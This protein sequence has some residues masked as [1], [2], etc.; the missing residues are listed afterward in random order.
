MQESIGLAIESKVKRDNE[1]WKRAAFIGW[2]NYLTVPKGKGKKAMNFAAWLKMLGLGE[3]V[4]K[5]SGE[6]LSI[7]DEVSLVKRL[8]AKARKA[9]G[10]G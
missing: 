1:E 6:K 5:D 7:K 2:Q 9:F 3:K 8:R 10:G 4:K